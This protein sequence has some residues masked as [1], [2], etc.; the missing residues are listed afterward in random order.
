MNDL[1]LAGLTIKKAMELGAEE[2][3]VFLVTLDKHSIE[4]AD[5]GI[6]S[7]RFL[8]EKVIGVRVVI[9]KRIGITSTNVESIKDVEKTVREA[10]A[11]A[12]ASE[13]DIRWSGLPS[14]LGFTAI[15]GAYDSK[16]KK[17]QPS[18]I[19]DY[20][21]V[22]VNAVHEESSHKARVSTSKLEIGVTRYTIANPYDSPVSRL[23]S[24]ILVNLEA[25][26]EEGGM[27]STGSIIKTK[28]KLDDIVFEKVGSEAASKALKFIDAKPIETGIY[29]V[30]LTEK[31][32]AEALETMI[33]G[34][35]SAEWV[36]EGRSPLADRIG[37][38]IASSKLTIIDDPLMPWGYGSKEFD[39]EGVPTQRVEIIK[40]GV[41]QSFIY[42][43]YTARIHRRESTGNAHRTPSSRPRPR[44]NNL[45]C[46][47]G[48]ASFEEMIEN[49]K[50]LVVYDTVGLWL[51]NPVS[52]QFNA[53][54]THGILYDKGEEVS[55][56]KG[57][58]LSADFWKI[59]RE[60]ILLIGKD[61]DNLGN[62]YAPAILIGNVH[63]SGK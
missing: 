45:V 47:S 41:L 57:V 43:T 26:V 36:I 38:S 59:L 11:I 58:V 24:H 49:T 35:I 51:S 12:R 22:M 48:D 28:K 6:T 5:K 25:V 31:V 13:P 9:G 4:F 21:S 19:A 63:V 62:Y 2:S 32:F 56:V 27:R 15:E 39:D 34:P 54:V 53:T 52:G 37:E 30:V 50:T 16:V 42:D 60:N 17:L 44:P 3:D 1:E 33:S 29:N 23:S 14:S 18:D 20:I 61:V 40:E 55:R 10:I 8:S 7:Y 46:Q